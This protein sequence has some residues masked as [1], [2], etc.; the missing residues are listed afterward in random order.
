MNNNLYECE[1][2]DQECTFDN[3]LNLEGCI[4]N[5]YNVL[6]EIGRGGLS[7]V[8]LVYNIVDQH[9][10]AMKVQ[11]PDCYLE[12]LAEIEFVKKLPIEPNCFNNIIDYFIKTVNN[13]QYVISIWNLHACNL[14][15]LLKTQKYTN[16]IPYD[17]VNNIMKQLIK[18]I[19]ILHNKFKV[20]HGDIKPDNIF[21][22]GCNKR[23]NDVMI[24]YKKKY[25][26]KYINAKKDFWLGQNKNIKNIN[27]MKS[28]DKENIRSK[29][30]Q[31]IVT[32]IVRD[33]VLNNNYLEEIVL[34]IDNCSISI[35]DFGAKCEDI[36]TTTLGTRY[37]ISPEVILEG[38]C[39]YPVDIWA[40]GCT[41]YELLSGLILFDPIKDVNY[42]RDYYHLSLIN[43]TCGDFKIDF[44]KSTNKYK[45]FFK[46]NG[47]LCDYTRTECRLER[48]LKAINEKDNFNSIR[49]LLKS[50]LVINPA[51]RINILK[52]NELTT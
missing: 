3:N 46:K 35:G 4:L 20:F 22:K 43:D 6:Y 52:L 34:S 31:D 37:Y 39:S 21:L 8:W 12:G 40:I 36:C 27:K 42:S 23:D 49:I 48:K 29:I 16:G 44:L 33:F 19:D 11:D 9:F 51:E 15:E 41:Y 1:S 45:E 26:D 47:M 25:D 10:Y 14:D 17:I 30:H 18:G 24:E 2:S 38:K 13:N 5:K 7:I 28:S 32:Y 50:T